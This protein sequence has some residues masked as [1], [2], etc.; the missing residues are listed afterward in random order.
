MKQNLAP[1]I[2]EQ[3]GNHQQRNNISKV[4]EKIESAYY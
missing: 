1:T 3:M 4:K 2:E